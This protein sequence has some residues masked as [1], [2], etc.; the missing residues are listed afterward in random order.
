MEVYDRILITGGGGMLAKAL[1]RKLVVRGVKV[2]SLDRS[3]L[4]ITSAQIPRVFVEV[5]PTLV[6]N[7]AAYTK[8]D[9]AE[10]QR[11][12][13]EHVNDR[14]VAG[15][16]FESAQ[17]N[18]KLVHFSTDFVFDGT[19]RRPYRADD[20]TNPASWYG[21]TKQKGEVSLSNV[22]NLDYLLIRTA[23]L[24]G[25][26]GPNFVQTMLKAARDGKSLKVVRD[27]TG[28]PTFTHDLA[29][30]TLNL[31][32]AK[33][34][35]IFQ[36]TNAGQTTWFDFATAIFEEFGL[37]PDLSPTTAAAWKES[38][39]HSATRP[40]YSVLDTSAYERATGKRLRP[41]RDALKEYA[42]VV[43]EAP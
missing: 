23:W 20:A 18:A 26:G 9:L 5:K 19:A 35:G 40:A 14:A 13:A 6:I 34:R 36:V 33:A 21:M 1:A 16:G 25:P 42:R 32:D 15:L 39:P 4:D 38:H 43:R 22:P 10:E 30:A 11:A 24:Y 31:I 27:Q 29:E 28:S 41:W 12:L 2:T 8:V 7:C 17:M 37:K 3:A